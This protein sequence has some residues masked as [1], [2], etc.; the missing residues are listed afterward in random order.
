MLA[1][2]TQTMVNKLTCMKTDQIE[3]KYSKYYDLSAN[4]NAKHVHFARL[5]PIC[6]ML[7][8]IQIGNLFHPVFYRKKYTRERLS[9][10]ARR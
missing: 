4:N 7:S 5:S 1:F 10:R 3:H 8:L 9:C 6:F 2:L